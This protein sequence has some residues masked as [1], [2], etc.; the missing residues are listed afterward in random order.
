VEV[1]CIGCREPLY[2]QVLQVD[3]CSRLRDV[4]PFGS[5]E[6]LQQQLARDV[7]ATAEVLRSIGSV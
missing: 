3:F 5:V 6:E 2:G 4:Q 7:V 1:H